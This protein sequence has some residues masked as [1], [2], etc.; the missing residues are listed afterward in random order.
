M[1]HFPTRTARIRHLEALGI[2]AVSLDAIEDDEGHRLVVNSPAVAWNGLEAAFE[3]LEQTRPLL[4]HLDRHPVRVTIMG[5]GEIGKHAVEAATKGGSLDGSRRSTRCWP[6]VEVTTIGRGLTGDAAY[7]AERLQVTD[8]LVDATLRDDP[9]V[10][11]IRN[12]QIGL[13][14]PHAVICDLAVDPYL[15]DV[16]PPTVR[17]IEGIPQ[18]DLDRYVLDVDDPA[19]DELPPEVPSG[20]RRPV[21]SCYSWPGVHPKPCMELYGKQIAP[22]LETLVRRGGMS[23]VRAGGSFHERAL[24]PREPPGVAPSRPRCSRRSGSSGYAWTEPGISRQS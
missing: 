2:D 14:P 6:G 9:S 18:G 11:L 16:D 20:E 10:P 5:A 7:L 22:L 13:L 15:L 17:G 24:V 4:S 8:I 21:V 19:W 12:V 3:T 23:G 1:L